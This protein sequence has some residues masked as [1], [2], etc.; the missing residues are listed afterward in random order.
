MISPFLRRYKLLSCC[1][2][3]IFV[4]FL[5][6]HRSWTSCYWEHPRPVFRNLREQEHRSQVGLGS[7]TNTAAAGSS[8]F[9]VIKD[10]RTYTHTQR[11]ASSTGRCRQQR[12]CW[13]NVGLQRM[14]WN[15]SRL[16]P[17]RSAFQRVT[18]GWVPFRVRAL[19][20]AIRDRQGVGHTHQ[21]EPFSR[22][23]I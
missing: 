11:T 9:V 13:L 4:L 17:I 19:P 12:D 18:R 22:V 5:V 23:E 7:T 1:S 20:L 2:L 14:R 16:R 21:A 6:L 15:L 3:S 10:N 8:H